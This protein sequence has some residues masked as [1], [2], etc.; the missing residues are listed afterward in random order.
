MLF[1]ALHLKVQLLTKGQQRLIT[2]LA[3][4]TEAVVIAHD[5]ATHAHACDKTTH[6]LLVALATEI[7]IEVYDN[8][9]VYAPLRQET[10]ALLDS[11]EQLHILG[12]PHGDARVRIEGDDNTL[13]CQA[14]SHGC[15][16]A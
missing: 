15:K 10:S 5:H 8:K 7:I 12:T 4:T 16:A 13:A 14:L 3:T 11:R 2:S 6:K 9:V 1:H